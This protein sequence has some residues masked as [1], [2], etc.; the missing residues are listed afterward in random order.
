MNVPS[1]ITLDDLH[2]TTLQ[3]LERMARGGSQ[4]AA[5]AALTYCHKYGL[6]LPLWFVG[7]AAQI[8]KKSL[9]KNSR[10]KRGR[11][12]EPLDRHRQD[13]IDYARYCE[14]CEVREKQ[15]ELP[16]EIERLRLHPKVTTSMLREKEKML[17]W[18]GQ[19]LERAFQCASMILA[20][21]SAF[22]GPDAIKASHSRVRKVLLI[23]EQA[24][25]YHMLDPDFLVSLGMTQSDLW[26]TSELKGEA[27][28]TVYLFD[29]TL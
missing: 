1:H 26:G 5:A 6:N 29:L 19:S 9:G 27:R 4:I 7:P 28:K 16:R 23:G 11:S 8:A 21:T 15:N 10:A 25:R 20:T 22:G 2:K 3:S 24:Y 18:A 13:M 12:A 17:D 14:V